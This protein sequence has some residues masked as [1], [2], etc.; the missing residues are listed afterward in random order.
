[1]EARSVL[2]QKRPDGLHRDTTLGQ[3]R[4]TVR[5]ELFQN[6]G[7]GLA[8][9]LILLLGPLLEVGPHVIERRRSVLVRV[10]LRS[11]ELLELGDE[12]VLGEVRDVVNV[13]AN[14]GEVDV[15]EAALRQQLEHRLNGMLPPMSP[16]TRKHLHARRG[17]VHEPELLQQR[18]GRRSVHQQRQERDAAHE[19]KELVRLQRIERVRIV[20][21]ARKLG[22]S[23]EIVE[24]DGERDA[25]GA[26]EPAPG[27][28]DHFLGGRLEADAGDDGVE[29][30]EE[31]EAQREEDEVQHEQ[32][33]PILGVEVPDPV[34]GICD[35]RAPHQPAQR[36]QHGV[37]KMLHQNPEV[38]EQLHVRDKRASQ[39]IRNEPARQHR[40]DAA[41]MPHRIRDVIAQI[42][43]RR[44]RR[45][46][47]DVLLPR[48]VPIQQPQA[49][50]Q[51]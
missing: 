32:V 28:E 11:P 38:L 4:A 49:E 7:P 23:D 8:A 19:A 47:H 29:R 51:P 48:E 41:R 45:D 30:G 18:P 33:P 24:G 5:L 35:D 36:E 22:G 17:L 14:H 12:L 42:R 44:G 15:R 34:G 27:L 50:H 37:E 20:C 39:H 31:E 26:A 6:R 16:I 40:D 2:P 21:L 9:L 25:D 3:R 10:A 1:M 43:E 13:R 46:L